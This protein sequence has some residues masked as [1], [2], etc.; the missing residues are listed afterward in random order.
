MQKERMGVVMS[1]TAGKERLGVVMKERTGIIKV[2]ST[3]CV[4][5]G[6]GRTG[7]VSW[8]LHVLILSLSCRSVGSHVWLC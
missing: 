2:H 3:V 5:S 4:I 6:S 7:Q 1:D 8:G